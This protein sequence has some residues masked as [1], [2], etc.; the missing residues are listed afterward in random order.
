MGLIMQEFLV[1]AANVKI[2][3]T[4]I[5]VPPHGE[6]GAAMTHEGEEF[7]FIL[8]G[9]LDVFVAEYG[10]Y[11]LSEGDTIYYPCTL[12]HRWEN[13]EASEA[14]FLAASTPPSY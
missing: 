14:L 5:S 4:I 10:P 12:P 1:D 3:A 8:R 9:A 6:S 11:R 7:L 2:G 13:P